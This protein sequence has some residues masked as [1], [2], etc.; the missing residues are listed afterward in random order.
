MEEAIKEVQDALNYKDRYLDSD[1]SEEYV[2]VKPKQNMKTKNP[3]PLQSSIS[4]NKVEELKSQLMT[5]IHDNDLQKKI[6]P[7][8]NIDVSVFQIKQKILNQEESADNDPEKV[9]RPSKSASSA[10]I[11]SLAKKLEQEEKEEE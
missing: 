9:S 11:S 6:D 5:M 4:G 7:K 3:E 1:E 10:I 8:E 2:E